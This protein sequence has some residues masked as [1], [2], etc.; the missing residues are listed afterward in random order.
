[1]VRFHKHEIDPAARMLCP[2]WNTVA[3]V[4]LVGLIISITSNWLGQS[5]G[6]PRLVKDVAGLL[7]LA[8]VAL[9]IWKWRWARQQRSIQSTLHDCS[10]SDDLQP[11]RPD[12]HE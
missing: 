4:F 7:I 5:L 3:R 11:R 8:Y 10:L 12:Q 2:P 9:T 6:N 1:M